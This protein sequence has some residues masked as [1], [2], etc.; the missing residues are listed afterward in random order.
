M[1]HFPYPSTIDRVDVV[2][3]GQDVQSTYDTTH[4]CV[5]FQCDAIDIAGEEYIKMT[6]L[7]LERSTEV[8][9]K[10]TSGTNELYICTI[11]GK[12][13]VKIQKQQRR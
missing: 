3:K 12:T 7:R 13:L 8:L 2:N 4:E 6:R 11:P 1:P 10:G 9:L 5:C